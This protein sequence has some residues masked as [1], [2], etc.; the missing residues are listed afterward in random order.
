MKMMSATWQPCCLDINELTGSHV[1]LIIHC[2]SS[3]HRGQGT[4]MYVVKLGQLWQHIIV[5][6]LTCYLNNL[7]RFVLLPL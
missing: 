3:T 6:G 2:L 5:I 7:E 4:H 1:Q